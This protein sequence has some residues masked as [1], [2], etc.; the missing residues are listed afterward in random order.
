MKLQRNIKWDQTNWS[1]VY[2]VS[3]RLAPHYKNILVDQLSQ[4]NVKFA[5]SFNE[6]YNDV[7][8][9]VSLMCTCLFFDDMKN[10]VVIR[11]LGSAFL[12]HARAADLLDAL[13]R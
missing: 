12:V 5:S 6:A 8:P 4:S 13:I 3:Y 7:F 2:I 1:T 11:Y 10:E 9:R